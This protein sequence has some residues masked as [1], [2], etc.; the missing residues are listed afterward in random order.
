MVVF[1]DTQWENWAFSGGRQIQRLAIPACLQPRM[2][3]GRVD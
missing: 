1:K 2:F 3:S